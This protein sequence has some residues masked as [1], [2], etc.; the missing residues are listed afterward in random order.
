MRIIVLLSLVLFFNSFIHH[1]ILVA[2]EVRSPKLELCVSINYTHVNSNQRTASF[3]GNKALSD[4][5]FGVKYHFFASKGFNFVPG[6][7]YNQYRFYFDNMAYSH[8][9]SL[10]DVTYYLK[11]FTVPVAIRYNWGKKMKVFAQTGVFVEIHNH[12]CQETFS[13]QFPYG[14]ENSL[15]EKIKTMIFTEIN[16]GYH[17]GLGTSIPISKYRLSLLLEYRHGLKPLNDDYE[18]FKLDILRINLGFVF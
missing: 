10:H 7:E 9:G 5:G 13:N 2:Q 11:R 3:D 16:Y 12:A 6:I 17:L 1:S 14:D 8:Y 15:S 18:K 4:I